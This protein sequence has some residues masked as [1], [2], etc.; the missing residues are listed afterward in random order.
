MGDDLS[1]DFG[2]FFREQRQQPLE[3]AGAFGEIN[4]SLPESLTE[5]EAS[6][7]ARLVSRE[8][9]LT[10]LF[11]CVVTRDG[12]IRIT[13]G[14]MRGKQIRIDIN[15]YPTTRRIFDGIAALAERLI[16]DE[17]FTPPTFVPASVVEDG[18]AEIRD[19]AAGTVPVLRGEDSDPPA[20]SWGSIVELHRINEQETGR[21]LLDLT[22]YLRPWAS[23][24]V[25]GLRA[26]MFTETER[27]GEAEKVRFLRSVKIPAMRGFSCQLNGIQTTISL[28]EDHVH[29]TVKLDRASEIHVN[30]GAGDFFDFEDPNPLAGLR[31]DFSS[32]TCVEISV[33][34]QDA[35]IQAT[36]REIDRL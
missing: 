11:T 21:Q 35:T 33:V 3:E 15:S 16:D 22:E 17:S 29:I 2:E 7:L 6:H 27:L 23:D 26:D 28:Q 8:L 32:P 4:L 13:E 10:G 12:I 30:I 9:G 14:N 5:D 1:K 20:R 24:L 36:G 19:A 31:V 34:G 18:R 25:A